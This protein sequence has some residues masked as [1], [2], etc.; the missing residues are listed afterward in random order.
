MRISLILTV[1]FWPATWLCCKATESPDG[2][3]SSWIKELGS[4]DEEVARG[5]AVELGEAGKRA[6]PALMQALV[7]KNVKV[8]RGAAGAL[9]F[10]RPR[11]VRAGAVR[12]LIKAVK[13][14]DYEVRSNAVQA[15]G[16]GPEGKPAV[17][18]LIKVLQEEEDNRPVLASHAARSLGAIGPAA[19]AAVP[20][21]K[22]ALRAE[23][24]W[25]RAAVAR[26]LGQIGP[27]SKIA[28]HE[29]AVALHDDCRWVRLQAV[30]ALPHIGIDAVDAIPALKE[31]VR[32]KQDSLVYVYAASAWAHIARTDPA[33]VQALI[34]ALNYSNHR[35]RYTAAD[36]LGELGE[37]ARTSIRALQKALN[38]KNEYVRKS[39]ENALK[40][41]RPTNRN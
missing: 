3:I 16:M 14:K 36:C 27:A 11:A 33:P 40:K 35:N 38:D 20:V 21:L 23:D 25:L 26:A 24:S 31:I 22:N 29:L 30:W 13:D 32:A 15:L 5:A 1:V 17:P 18:I 19:S 34:A 7:D 37:R 10:I 28:V 39:A 8:R 41:I 6:V 4:K 12:A 9:R 2:D